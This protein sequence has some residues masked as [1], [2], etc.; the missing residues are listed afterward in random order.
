MG[1]TPVDRQT[2][3]CQNITFP[4]YYVRAAVNFTL[5]GN[6]SQKKEY[7]SYKRGIDIKYDNIT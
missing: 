7:Y 3:T 4:S 2:D 6:T 1:T 5:Q